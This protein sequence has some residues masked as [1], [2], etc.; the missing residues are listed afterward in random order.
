MLSLEEFVNFMKNGDSKV[1]KGIY[2]PELFSL[3]VLQQPFDKQDYVSS[4]E[5][6]VT[7]FGMAFNN[8]IIGMLAHNFA[9]GRLFQKLK[10]ND[11]IN[12]VYGDGIIK[13]YKIY[14]TK[15]YKA[16]TPNNKKSNFIDLETN[17]ILSASGLFIKMY[18]GKHHLTLQTCIRKDDEMSW[19]RLFVVAYPIESIE[20]EVM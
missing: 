4:I 14:K 19:G 15:Q 1:I 2:V 11:I 9:S 16:E 3:R 6:T 8:N 7:Q 17:K 20:S 18:A 12:I 10:V 5:G 13:K